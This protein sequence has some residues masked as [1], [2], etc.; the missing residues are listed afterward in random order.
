MI[1]VKHETMID[2]PI[3]DVFD[4]LVD[5]S[6]YS[7]WLPKSRVFLDSRKTS[8]G[9]TRTGTTFI[10]KTRIGKYKGVVEDF[11]RPIKVT[12]RMKLR[13][14]GLDVMESRPGYFL[15]PVDG[16]TKLRHVAVGKLF[17]IF[18]LMEPYVAIRAREER[19]RTVNVLKESL[20]SSSPQD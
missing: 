7:K 2:R 1:K 6:G 15:E 14:L 5:I 12:F 16:G 3:E 18:K 19:I 17:G 8:Q 11:Q 13:W 9:P 20:E 4:R 10:D